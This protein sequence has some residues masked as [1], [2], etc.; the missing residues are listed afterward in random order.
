MPRL[1]VKDTELLK[2]LTK[3]FGFVAVRQKGS[4]VRLVDS[5]SH[6]VTIPIHN[7]ELKQGTLIAILNQAGLEKEDILDYL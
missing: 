5:K 2:L 1:V 3:Y 6:Y 7:K 4:H